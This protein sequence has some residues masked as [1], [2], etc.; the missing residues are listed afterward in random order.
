[1]RHR[2][3]PLGPGQGGR[4]R[5]EGRGSVCAGSASGLCGGDEPTRSVLTTNK[6]PVNGLREIGDKPLSGCL[7]RGRT[8]PKA[9][10][11]QLESLLVTLLAGKPNR[12]SAE[13][14]PRHRGSARRAAGPAPRSW[15]QLIATKYG[16][17]SAI[18]KIV[19]SLC[20]R[21][22]SEGRPA[23]V[24]RGEPH[25]LV[26]AC[27]LAITRPDSWIRFSCPRPTNASRAQHKATNPGCA[28]RRSG[29]VIA[30]NT[31]AGPAREPLCY[32]A[33]GG[34]QP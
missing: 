16:P 19:L 28:F 15:R 12:K 30:I 7:N 6:I 29:R 31:S 11:N 22:K 26:D 32:T 4:R 13:R 25:C 1:M 14:R 34:A 33:V 17:A 8:L 9:Q 27:R 23:S 24:A 18:F 3:K 2:A 21:R 10:E 20:S 5:D